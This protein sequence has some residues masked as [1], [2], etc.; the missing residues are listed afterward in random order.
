MRE[1]FHPPPP[2]H[3][4]DFPTTSWT[5][6]RKVQQ[7][8]EADARRAME[9]ICRSYWYPIYAFARRSGFNTHD[10]EDVTQWFFQDMITSE[11]LQR[12][13]EDRGHLR[14]FMLAMLKRIITLRRRSE[15]AAKRGGGREATVSFDELEAEEWYQHE[16]AEITDPELLFDR[17]WAE[18]VLKSAEAKLRNEWSSSD[19][20]EMFDALSEFLP[21]GDNATPYPAVAARLR[22]EQPTLRLQIHRLRKRY[23]KLI[24]AEI[25]QTVDGP[26]ELKT[27]RE[28]L[29]ATIG[30]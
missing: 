27:E 20:L 11:S 13:R 9:N 14:T 1:E 5:L 7:G 4:R 19:D 25:A 18:G 26:N 3:K 21:L 30:R 24:E 12:A 29:M 28:H 16:P 23:A 22:I 2:P 8:S 15:N 10:A 17:A 6:I